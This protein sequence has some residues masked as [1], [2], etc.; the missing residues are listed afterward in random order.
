M[1]TDAAASDAPEKR[2]AGRPDIRLHLFGH[3]VGRDP[4]GKS[5]L[6]RARKS[7]ALLAVLALSSPRPVLRTHLTSLL[8]SQ[9]EKEQARASLRQAVHELQETLGP[10]S[11]MLIAERNH[12]ALQKKGLWVDVLDL[13][14]EVGTTEQL[15]D[16]FQSAFLEDLAG[17]DP[18]FDRW[19]GQERDR[20]AGMARTI[21]E[22]VL[23]HS[24]G[25]AEILK[26]AERLLH[27]D[28]AHEGAWLAMIRTHATRG[29]RGAAM[30][31]FERC[32]IALAER[33]G[34][35]P[36]RAILELVASIKG[37]DG[38]VADA[39][40]APLPLP[41]PP[42]GSE[43]PRSAS[44]GVRLGVMPLRPLDPSN[45]DGLA[46][47][48]TDEIANGL[49]RFRGISCVPMTSAAFQ[50]A[51][52]LGTGR[53]MAM[54]GD[55]ADP[56]TWQRLKLD[57]L[58]EGTV[59]R[60]AKRIRIMARLIDI[61]ADG[62]VIWSHRFDLNEAD[63]LA[64]QDEIASQIVAQIDPRILLRQSERAAA[65]EAESV[66]P[67]DLLLQSIPAVYRL[68][69]TG[70]A[71]AGCH[72]D[73]A[74]TED[75]N[76]AAA[77]AWY[78]YWHLFQVGQGWAADPDATSHRAAELARRAVT[79]DP[80]DARSLTLAGHVRGFL[81]KQADE[82]SALHARAIALNPNLALAW[83][84]SGL[85]QCYRGN[86]AEAMRLIKQAIRLSPY[87]PHLF[88]FNMALTM[89]HL[90]RCEYE[91]AVDIGRQAIELNPGFTSS[92][93]GHLSALGHLGRMRDAEDTKAV[94]LSLEPN[95]SVRQAVARS[96][97]RR[98]EDRE[99]YAQGLRLARLPEG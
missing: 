9:R 39:A 80:G 38:A 54:P 77:H 21:A 30:A 99:R 29:D 43:R 7:R 52:G 92:Y 91:E 82:A 27:V 73:V 5:I 15:L 44:T 68:E 53:S 62:E 56:G 46:I 75:P 72:L 58:L 84:F 98:P 48:L 19:V 3:M 79:L 24:H 65:L 83:C 76:N 4:E 26:S 2:A 35:A 32:R 16:L 47:G 1:L 67:H 25:A 45:D 94:L 85:A 87:D 11:R 36:G 64:A 13:G 96:P 63:I 95:F 17:L 89:P 20:L 14:R 23:A 12:L 31:A 33:S 61:W 93:K 78:A 42:I 57:F 18:S 34:I 88:F 37:D 86:H 81:G 40:D 28:P 74:V 70:F 71:T 6:P 60:S 69:R 55:G 49:S 97:M 8:W 50:P 51:A 41:A 90:L 10:A 66:T 59:Q 22:N